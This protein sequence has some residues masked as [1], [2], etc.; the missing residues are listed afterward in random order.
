MSFLLLSRLWVMVF[1]HYFV[2]GAWYVTMGTYTT[3]K[4]GFLGGQVGLAY[5]STAVGAMV[6]PFVVGI[7]ADRFFA[8]QRLL[9]FLHLV[10]AALL[11]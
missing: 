6:S 3:A 11:Y 2:W 4:L 9:A 1:L 10:G 8:T 7:I 5:G